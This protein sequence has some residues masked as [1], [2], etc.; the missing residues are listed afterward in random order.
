MYVK[1]PSAPKYQL[2]INKLQEVGKTFIEYS[3]YINDVYKSNEEHNPG[4]KRKV[5]LV[6]DDMIAVMISN[7]IFIQW[8]LSCLLVAR[9]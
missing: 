8:S 4:N 9:N 5:M 3:N 7:K 6:F 2:L 1:N